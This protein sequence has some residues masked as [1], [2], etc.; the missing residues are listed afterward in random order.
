MP[1]IYAATSATAS[2]G[3]E[4]SNF[5]ASLGLFFLRLGAGFVLMYVE[6][7]QLA[8]QLWEHLWHGKAWSLI[9]TLT[10]A[11]MPMP[12]VLAVIMAMVIS[13]GSASWILGFV[14]RFASGVMLPVMAL[15]LLVANR[16]GSSTSY[17]EAAALYVFISLCLMISGPGWCS[18]DALFKMRRRKKAIYV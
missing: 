7:W 8:I 4:S 10:Q 6:G 13:L 15:A 17:S 14:T 9:D 18:L 3:G 12:K 1:N 16:A 11:E 5:A 2:R